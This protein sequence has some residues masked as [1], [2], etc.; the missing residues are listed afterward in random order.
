M[1]KNEIG[2]LVYKWDRK[3]YSFIPLLYSEHIDYTSYLKYYTNPQMN[4]DLQERLIKQHNE[5]T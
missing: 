4:A 2:Y 3:G 5:T 1:T